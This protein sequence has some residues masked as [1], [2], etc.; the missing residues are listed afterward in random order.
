MKPLDT[1]RC[2][3]VSAVR[4]HAKIL[5]HDA[6]DASKFFSEHSMR[7]FLSSAHHHNTMRASREALAA[8]LAA[9]Q[10]TDDAYAVVAEILQYARANNEDALAIFKDLAKQDAILIDDG[11]LSDVASP[12]RVTEMESL[13]R[14]AHEANLL[15]AV[16]REWRL[17]IATIRRQERQADTHY[18]DRLRYKAF[19]HLLN[20]YRERRLVQ[21]HLEGRL[22][23][24]ETWHLRQIC[25]RYIRRWIEKHRLASFWRFRNSQLKQ[26]GLGSWREKIAAM[27]VLEQRAEDAF[28][29]TASSICLRKWRLGTKRKQGARK[30]AH[31]Y[32]GLKYLRVWKNNVASRKRG[33]RIEILTARYYEHKNV[34]D[35]HILQGTLRSWRGKLITLKEQEEKADQHHE[36]QQ[37]QKTQRTAHNAVKTW[38]IHTAESQERALVADEHYENNLVRRFKILSPNGAWRTETRRIKEMEVRAGNF[39]DIKSEEMALRIFRK[40]RHQTA[41][42]QQMGEQADKFYD[43]HSEG[44][45]RKALNEWNTKT[46]EHRGDEVTP[47]APPTTPAARKQA[48]FTQE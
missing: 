25:E 36:Q 38:F 33:R 5:P 44:Y 29:Y 18:E 13:A 11:S 16:L 40:M 48:L 8:D 19:F 1:I 42:S 6:S 23:V 4:R 22:A 14:D 3:R 45:A 24:F 12:A 43:R 41:R 10:L 30:F 39:Y 46:G 47:T 32:L 2:S 31:F 27:R 20:T 35:L 34:K 15:Q 21:E 26:A 37:E 28:D 9:L 7:D 17:H